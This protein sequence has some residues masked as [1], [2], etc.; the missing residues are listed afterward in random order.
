ML[1]LLKHKTHFLTPIPYSYTS[2]LPDAM[3]RNYFSLYLLGNAR[4]LNE[5]SLDPFNFPTSYAREE[6]N[7][8]V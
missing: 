2:S 8:L 7:H 3:A 5:S 1:K 4:S 6:I